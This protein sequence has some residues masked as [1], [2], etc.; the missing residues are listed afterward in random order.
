MADGPGPR[1]AGGHG[2]PAGVVSRW[3]WRCAFALPWCCCPVRPH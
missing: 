2:R 1:L 3:A